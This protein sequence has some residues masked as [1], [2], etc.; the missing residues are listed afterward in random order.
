MRRIA[1]FA[2]PLLVA[3]LGLT[4]CGSSSSGGSST[5]QPVVK[6]T[7]S[8]GT[9]PKVTI[10][11]QK[12]GSA[13]D[14]KTLIHGTGPE[15]ASSDALVGNYAVYIW[16]GTTSKLA[17]STFTSSPALFSGSLLP[18]LTTALK[19][20][21]V[22]DRVLA[23]IPPKDGYG[24]KG[25]SS[26]GV[27]GT[28]TLVFVIDV[29]KAYAADASATGK[30]VSSGGGSLPTVTSEDPPTVTIPS[31]KQPP[32]GLVTKI[33][34]QGTGATVS[35]GDSVVVQYSGVIWRTGKVFSA[36]WQNGDPFG[37]T[38]DANPAQVISGWDTGLTGQ[39]VGTRIMLI[40]PP[41][42]GYGKTGSSSAGIKGTD[43]LVFIVDILGTF[44]PASSS[45]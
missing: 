35:K 13:L 15:V 40:I 1:L 30:T 36:S 32:T 9:S 39:K 27:K 17:Q 4:A 25:N 38:I 18:G 29:I 6:V 10:P 7:G 20:K 23:V 43:T 41:K 34:R 16:S 31:G 44:A 14:V 24:T 11:H 12:A 2:A 19:D 5:S 37:F 8:F 22:G 26:S 33:L 28:D 21:R 3:S 42:D 45:T